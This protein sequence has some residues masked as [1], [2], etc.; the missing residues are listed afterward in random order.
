MTDTKPLRADAARNRARILDVADAVFA[1][2]GT[3]ASTE[4]IA[5]AA[6]VGIGTVFRHFPTKEA[7]LEAV[8]TAHLRRLA[9]QAEALSE[10]EDTGAAFFGF[11][12][13]IVEQSGAKRAFA[14]ALTDAGVDVGRAHAEGAAGL[15]EALELLLRRAQEAGAVR[16]DI[17]VPEL[18]AVLVG[19]S[20]GAEQAGADPLVRARALAVVMDGLRPR[21]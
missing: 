7:L 16:D 9:E 18:M 6:G 19:A 5:K 15:R 20:L 17:G 1:E 11:F 13:L 14:N 3:S 8:F 4:E 10:A 2:R 21:R 12:A